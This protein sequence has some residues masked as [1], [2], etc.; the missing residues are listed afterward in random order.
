MSDPL[1]SAPA[2]GTSA[3]GGHHRVACLFETRAAAERAADDLMSAGIPRTAVQVVEQSAGAGTTSGLGTTGTGTTGATSTGSTLAGTTSAYDTGSSGGGLWDSIKSL[4][5]GDDD[6]HGYYEGVNRGQ[7]LVTVQTTNVAE[8]ERVSTILERHDP[9]DM[10]AQE[11]GWRSAGWA[12]GQRADVTQVTQTTT[13]PAMRST[14]SSEPAMAGRATAATGDEVIPIVEES[15]AVGKRA[16]SRG[17]VRVR[18]Y[19]VETPVSEEVRLHKERVHIER[20]PVD[21]AAAVGEDAFRK[22][23]ID[24][25]ETSEEAVVSKTARVVEEIGIRKEIGERTEHVT[26][27]TRR[28]EVEIEDERTKSLGATRSTTTDATL[29]EPT[30]TDAARVKPVDP[31]RR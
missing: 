5:T 16:V 4:F 26:G 2:G 7:T 27:T 1:Y 18:T 8:A 11:S 30:L 21:R 15:L 29:T 9:I 6:V 25:T 20:H 17:G 22:R 24:M 3:S 14:A 28:T 23:L 12:P 13:K 19:V 10:D 31:T